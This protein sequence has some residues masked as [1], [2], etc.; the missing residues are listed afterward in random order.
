MD[1]EAV[2]PLGDVWVGEHLNYVMRPVAASKRIHV[3]WGAGFRDAG[4]LS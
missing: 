4:A 3:D 2:V 1:E